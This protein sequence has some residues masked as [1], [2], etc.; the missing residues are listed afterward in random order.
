MKHQTLDLREIGKL[1]MSLGDAVAQAPNGLRGLSAAEKQALALLKSNL[2]N[3]LAHVDTWT[4]QSRPVLTEQD[5]VMQG[6][7]VM[8][9]RKGYTSDWD[10]DIEEDYYGL[11]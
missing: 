6:I 10:E 7:D 11:D 8:M 3:M 5:L 2:D 4:Y 1:Y 9:E